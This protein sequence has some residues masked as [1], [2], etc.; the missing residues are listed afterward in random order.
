MTLHFCKVN[1]IIFLHLSFHCHGNT[2]RKA[3]QQLLT[4]RKQLGRRSRDMEG[5][6]H[7]LTVSWDLTLIFYR[8]IITPLPIL[9]GHYNK[10]PKTRQLI[11]T[12]NSFLTVLKTERSRIKHWQTQCLMRTHFLPR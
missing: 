6:N 9:S 10:L 8:K 12:R 2:V 5:C 7:P 1:S 3:V 4:V 11:K